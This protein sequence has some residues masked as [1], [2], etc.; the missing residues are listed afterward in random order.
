MLNEP[1]PVVI[2]P[3]AEQVAAERDGENLIEAANVNNL[4]KIAPIEDDAFPWRPRA[5]EY[6]QLGVKPATPFTGV[7]ALYAQGGRSAGDRRA[8][9]PLLVQGLSTPDS[10]PGLMSRFR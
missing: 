4:C 3:R 1:L 10:A 6:F 2:S 7:E 9:T 8:H 5:E